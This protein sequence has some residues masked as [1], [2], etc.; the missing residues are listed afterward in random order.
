MMISDGDFLTIAIFSIWNCLTSTSHGLIE[1][2]AER[3]KAMKLSG[4]FCYVTVFCTAVFC[5]SL[6]CTAV[7]LCFALLG[8]VFL[9]FALL[10]YCV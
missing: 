6:F 2:N 9:S 1:C 8:S 3:G 7:L 10:S 5:V 4:Q